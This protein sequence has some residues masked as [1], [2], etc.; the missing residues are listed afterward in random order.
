LRL[1]LNR[2]CLD[3]QTLYSILLYNAIS[4]YIPIAKARGFTA[5]FGKFAHRQ[6]N[7]AASG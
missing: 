6:Q 4:P 3:M 7:R 2:R 5:F 1:L